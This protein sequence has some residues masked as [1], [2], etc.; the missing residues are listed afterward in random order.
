MQLK[1]LWIKDYKNLKDFSLDFEQGNNLS[2]L[3]GNN[4]SGKS[5]VL[6]AISGI[7][8]EWY[9]IP[10]SIFYT[11]YKIE[12][13]YDG[14][15]I[16]LQ[17]TDKKKVYYVDSALFEDSKVIP[18]LPS[19]VVALYSGEDLRL[20]DNF[21]FPKYDSYLK[22]VYRKGYVGKMGMY[23]VNK[24]LWNIALLTLITFSESLPDVQAFLATELGIVGDSYI[25][26]VRITFDFKDYDKNTNNLLKNFINTINPNQDKGKEYTIQEW[27]TNVNSLV[28]NSEAEPIETFNYLMQA[29]MPKTF[30]IIEKIQIL[31]SNGITLESLSEGEKKLIL[32][33][34][35]LEFVA[36]ENA[37]LLLDEPDANIHESRKSK[38]YKLLKDTPNRDIVMTSH[39]P[40]LAKIADKSELIYL[41][42]KEG[43]VYQVSTDK[44]NLVRK[45]SADEWNIMEAGGFLNSEKTLV[46]FEGKSDVDFVK[47]AIELLKEDEPK[48]DKIDVDFLSFNGTGNAETFLKNIRTIT[49]TKE[50]IF[51]FDRDEGG[52]DGMSHIS[53]KSKD[54]ESIVH[55]NDYINEEKNI[56]ASFLPYPSWSTSGDF[57]IE[58]Y[59]KQ[60]LLENIIQRIAQYKIPIT[61]LPKLGDAIK[62][63][64][65]ANYTT[66]LKEDFEGFKTLLNKLLEL[67]EIN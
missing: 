59:F 64:L 2:I 41:E 16:V 37:L 3:I 26:H 29:F 66:Y 33:K 13:E 6:E 4:G 60:D 30:K 50:I 25:K 45:L 21:Y 38:L 24:Y 9:G 15:Y 12:Y 8:T 32:I 58:D 27:R 67:L 49:E 17:K 36:D 52:K 48:Y 28:V 65:A 54:D 40:I 44:L 39:S 7:F 42:S 23:Y 47:R 18:Y 31:F 20:F 34:A 56:K 35:V 43:K 51:F 63:E 57:M 22:D 11:D 46:L 5:N 55:Y 10:A 14:K 19:N 62:K 1:K 61:R 53:E